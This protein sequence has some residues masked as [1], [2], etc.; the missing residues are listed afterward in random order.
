MVTQLPQSKE[1]MAFRPGLLPF[2]RDLEHLGSHTMQTLIQ[3]VRVEPKTLHIG[4]PRG[5]LV[6]RL[7]TLLSAQLLLCRGLC[8]PLWSAG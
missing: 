7:G 3:R 5:P 1:R 6:R 4:A 2:L 8:V